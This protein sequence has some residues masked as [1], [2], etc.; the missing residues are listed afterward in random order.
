M[1]SGPVVV[2][3]KVIIV[4]EMVAVLIVVK[5]SIDIYEVQGKKYE[6]HGENPS[7]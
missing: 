3:M 2:V 1:Y 5:V 4:I 6:V 7:Q